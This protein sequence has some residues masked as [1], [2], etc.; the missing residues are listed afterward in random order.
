MKIMAEIEVPDIP[1]C[2]ECMYRDYQDCVIF[3]EVIGKNKYRP[4]Q[5]CIEARNFARALATAK[6]EKG[7]TTDEA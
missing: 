6:T 1:D 4:C 2:V 5:K 3:C 7:G